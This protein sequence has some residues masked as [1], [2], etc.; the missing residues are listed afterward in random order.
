[1]KVL[2][3]LVELIRQLI[4]PLQNLYLYS[5]T[6]HTKTQSGIQTNDHTITAAKIRRATVIICFLLCLK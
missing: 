3:H 5:T 1:M 6:V 2:R 4:S